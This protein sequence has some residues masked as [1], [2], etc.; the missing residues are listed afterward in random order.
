MV[1]KSASTSGQA[2]DIP[3][4]P[5]HL[6]EG[7]SMEKLRSLE[8]RLRELEFLMGRMEETL[9][10]ISRSKRDHYV[11]RGGNRWS[12]SRSREQRGQRSR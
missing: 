7:K 5:V 4:T 3:S 12:R 6:G 11:E 2:N 8:E 1:E 10:R 9:E